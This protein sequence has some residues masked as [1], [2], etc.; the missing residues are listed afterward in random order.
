VILSNTSFINNGNWLVLDIIV[1]SF[2]ELVNEI[3][4]ISILKTPLP[5]RLVWCAAIDGRY[6][7]KQ[8]WDFMLL[9]Q[10]VLPWRDWL[11]DKPVPPS[12][13]FIVWRCMHKK[14]PTD[15]NLRKRG[16][17]IVSGCAMCL[18]NEESTSHLFLN[19]Q[20]AARL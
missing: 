3:R 1:N 12:H 7:T 9:V 13:S 11:W 10:H 6:T 2:R 20:F 18:R 19:R 4:N 16:C 14:M 15:E 5:D 17:I 8:S